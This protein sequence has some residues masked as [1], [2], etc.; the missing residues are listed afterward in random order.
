[1]LRDEVDSEREG[2]MGRPEGEVDVVGLSVGEV[3]SEDA[4]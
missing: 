2:G 1:M 3:G 4:T